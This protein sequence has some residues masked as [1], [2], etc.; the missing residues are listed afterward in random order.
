M[1]ELTH[2]I[3]FAASITFACTTSAAGNNLCVSGES[4]FFS[5]GVEKRT[6]SLCLGNAAQS[7]EY[8]EYRFGTKDKIELRYRGAASD[9]PLRFS[10]S[11]VIYA[12]NSEDVIWFRNQAVL[13]RLHFPMRGG[14]SLQVMKDGKYLTEM[15]CTK[16]WAN[17][18]GEPRAPSKA[19]ASV[20]SGTLD[21][22]SKHWSD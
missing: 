21:E 18:E 4:T 15:K 3:F 12:S 16:G 17:T 2:L 1:R 10:R 19:I 7:D 20:P 6:V 5:C 11:E 13:Y 22:I 9:T 14:P 8:L